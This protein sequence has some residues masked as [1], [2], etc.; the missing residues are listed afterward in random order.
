[1]TINVQVGEPIETAGLS[2]QDRDR[3]IEDVRGAI[4]R[5]LSD[6]TS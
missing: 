3:L 2:I 6:L 1:M 5:L 4:T